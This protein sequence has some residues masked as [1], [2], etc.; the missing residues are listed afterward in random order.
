MAPACSCG[1][2]CQPGRAPV[3]RCMGAAF[4]C[5]GRRMAGI[6]GRPHSAHAGC[7]VGV[8]WWWRLAGPRSAPGS[9][10]GR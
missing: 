6:H 2:R 10:G 1:R 4:N 3:K 8:C 5:S 9:V 7:L